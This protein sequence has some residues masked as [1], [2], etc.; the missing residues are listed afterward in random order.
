MQQ[1]IGDAR[2]RNQPV[3]TVPALRQRRETHQIMMLTVMA[4]CAERIGVP[5]ARQPRLS[6]RGRQ[7]Q[8]QPYRL[9][10]VFRALQRVR[11]GNQHALAVQL[12][13]KIGDC[14]RADATNL[15]RPLRVASRTVL[16]AA[17]IGDHLLPADGVTRE[18]SLIG[19]LIVNQHRQQTENEGR[20]GTGAQRQPLSLRLIGQIAL[21]RAHRNKACA[22]LCRLLH[23]DAFGVFAQTSAC[24]LRIF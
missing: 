2:H 13:G 24:H 7:H 23:K 16:F 17:N 9:L 20:I 10:T 4:E 8:P 3:N 21:Q 1:H 12:A 6:Q 11:H 22:A 15:S 5:T 14:C 19:A 18:E